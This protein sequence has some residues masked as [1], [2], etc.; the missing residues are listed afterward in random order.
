MEDYGKLGRAAA[1]Y[2][3]CSKHGM[4]HR[5]SRTACHVEAWSNDILVM[6]LVW[7]LKF[8]LRA[9]S[10]CILYLIYLFYMCIYIYYFMSIVLT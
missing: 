4:F 2:P 8:I 6:A 3:H 9:F 7:Q 1:T 10:F 5:F